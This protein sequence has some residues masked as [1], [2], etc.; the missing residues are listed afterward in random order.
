[1]TNAIQELLDKRALDELVYGCMN[2]VDA[3]DWK[4][5]RGLLLDDAEFDITDHGVAPDETAEIIKGA[6]QLL[7]VVKSVLTGFEAV[8]H[9]VTN[10]VHR[11]DGDEATTNA[12]VYAEHFLNNDRGDRSVTCGGRYK[13]T[14]RR[15]QDGWKVAS[16]QLRI[17]WF[18]G[19]PMLYKLAAEAVIRAAGAK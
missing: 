11:V 17:S 4:T 13:I 19:N 9:H 8:Q 5:Y 1:M 7:S 18:R 2:A 12:Y 10:M 15:T 14:S 3:L 16:W 6:D